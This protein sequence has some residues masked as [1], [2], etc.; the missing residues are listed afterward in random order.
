MGNKI[1]WVGRLFLVV[2]ATF[3]PISIAT[4]REVADL[5]RALQEQPD[6]VSAWVALG[7]AYVGAGQFVLARDAFLEAIAVDHLAG[8]AHFGL[9]LA[10]FGRGN[11]QAAL[12]AFDEVVRLYPQRFDG[13]YN[14]AV[15]LARLGNPDEAAQA[16]RDAITQAGPEAT[17]SDKAN[18][19]LGLASQL[20]AAGSFSEATS[21][22]GS[23]LNIAAEGIDLT[24]SEADALYQAGWG[25]EVLPELAELESCFSDYRI[26]ILVSDIYVDQGQFDYALQSLDWALH[27]TEDSQGRANIL[28]KLG[29]LRRELGRADEAI[30]AFQQAAEVS[31]G[32][33]EAHYNLG[34]IYYESGQSRNAVEALEVAVEVNP[35]SGEALLALAIAYDQFSLSA[36]ALA[37]T[38]SALQLLT[39]PLL[40]SEATFIL[41]RAMYRQGD[42]LGA[43]QEFSQVITAQPDNALAQLWSGLVEYQQGNY[44]S[45]VQ[46]Y[47]RAVQLDPGSAEVQINLGSAYL[48]AERYQDA[49]QV[50]RLLVRQNPGDAES[51]YHLGWALLSQNRRGAARDAWERS[52]DLGYQPALEA[53]GEYF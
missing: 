20:K 53:L 15:T 25:L 26:G 2:L 40:I 44:R 6:D 1:E 21:F 50:Y 16:F 48:A 41:G 17:G 49:E 36:Q 27:R 39:D 42:Y 10:E 46:Y 30:L 34:V 19:C 37:T 38:R 11:V 5:L 43:A 22:H 7:T 35:E 47:E 3:L 29:L 9:G 28:V 24:H 45:A 12:H 14:R 51:F 32:F 33:W 31:P 18:A 4:A 52:R 23:A 13:H 8:D